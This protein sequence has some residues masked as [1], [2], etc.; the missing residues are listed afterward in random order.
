MKNDN[1]KNKKNKTLL[2]IGIITTILLLTLGITYAAFV[3]QKTGDY[4]QEVVLG[5]IYMHYQ[6][7]NQLL[8][9]NA[10]PSSFKLNTLKLPSVTTGYKV[11]P[12]MKEQELNTLSRCMGYF[13]MKFELDEGSTWESF[14]KGEGTEK[15]GMTLQE[16]LNEESGWETLKVEGVD[17]IY[18]KE[19]DIYKPNPIMQTQE[20]H[21]LTAC[22]AR[23]TWYSGFL[24]IIP[25]EMAAGNPVSYC[26][27]ETTNGQSFQNDI[28]NASGDGDL[29]DLFEL[30]SI[31]KDGEKNIVNPVMKTQT[32]S[33]E[34]TNCMLAVSFSLGSN[35]IFSDSTLE[36][37]CKGEGTTSDGKTFQEYLDGLSIGAPG[38]QELLTVNA[39]LE[40][41]LPE[42]EYSYTN[43]IVNPNME[44]EVLESCKTIVDD[45]LASTTT[46]YALAPDTQSSSEN[47][48]KGIGHLS[49]RNWNKTIG[50]LATDT[51]FL[52]GDGHQLLR[53]GVVL[54]KIENLPYFEFTISGKNTYSKKDIYYDIVLSHGDNHETRTERIRD[55][56][57]R[58]TLTEVDSKGNEIPLANNISLTDLKN[59]ERV[60]VETIPKNTMEEINKTYRLYMNIAG[61]TKIC[62][63]EVN[64]N[65]DYYTDAGKSP[66]W[67][68]VFA[69]VKVNVTG[70][71][72]EK[73]YRYFVHDFK[74]VIN[75]YDGTSVTDDDGTIYLSGEVDKINYNYVSYSGRLWRITA[76]YPD[77]SM[78]LVTDDIVDNMTWESSDLTFAN[79]NIKTYLNNDFLNT[80]D[81]Y[82][83]VIVSNYKWD[84]AYF[85]TSLEIGDNDYVT[86]PVGLLNSY[87]YS[88]SYQNLEKYVSCLNENGSNNLGCVVD[89]GYLVKENTSWWL[90]NNKETYMYDNLLL[91]DYGVMVT[92]PGHMGGDL[93]LASSIVGVRPSIVLKPKVLISDGDGSY[94]N[95][96]VIN[97]GN[98]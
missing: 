52:Q 29:V 66:N 96:Y 67:N 19:G 55:D 51:A 23:V 60:Y 56:L 1:I 61:S 83:N 36:S 16:F 53:S 68:D 24:P 54:A 38:T 31:I 7:K 74:E 40:E 35:I 58:F 94:D 88:R 72:T 95:P 2:I 27:G 4:N 81:N 20:I 43:L 9:E 8:L 10:M 80:L 21:E 84:T 46:R 47:F 57:L 32:F 14:C 59:G 37:Y 90:L 98:N 86:A 91:F 12:V 33:E 97:T 50:D 69:S 11:N 18:I 93:I 65:C 87:E 34:L 5:D 15:Y 22:N 64:R 78:K 63:G 49:T 62:G 48:C 70:D 39:I 85:V 42:V 3:Y 6:E 25:S 75:D 26:R 79:S 77:G 73:N 13:S 82:Q 17:D 89:T 30:K 41:T 71:F 28:N 92:G 45:L 76:I 44:G